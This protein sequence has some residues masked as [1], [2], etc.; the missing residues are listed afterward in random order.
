MKPK[1]SIIP[2]GPNARKILDLDKK[3]ISS[4]LTR[5]YPLVIEKAK[6]VSI[7]D[8]DGNVFLD[9]SSLLGVGNLGHSNEQIVRTITEQIKKSSHIGLSDFYSE[10]PAVFADRLTRF[11][12]GKLNRVFFSNSG[13]ESVETAIKLARYYTGRK[14]FLAFHKGYHGSTTCGAISLTDTSGNDI[15]G[16]LLPVIHVPY[17][18]CYRCEFNREYPNCNLECINYIKSKIFSKVS[19][20]N[21]AAVFIEPILGSEIVVPPKEFHVRL[22]NLCREN[23][24]LYIADEVFTGN[25]RTGK[26]LASEYFDIV[27]DI[28]CMS[29]GIGGGLP[30]GITIANEKIMSWGEGSHLSTFGGNSLVCAVGLTVLDIFSQDNI[31]KK[32]REDGEYILRYFENL[33]KHCNLIGNIRGKGLMIGVEIVKDKVYK[34]PAVKE[35]ENIILQ[36]F[37]KGLILHSGESTIKILPPLII[38]KEDIDNGLEILCNLMQYSERNKF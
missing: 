4:S 30:L 2:P 38:S 11:L 16:E 23:G 21:I 28:V 15:F 35:K 25:F 18:Y 14:Y 20:K 22:K 26:F 36:A 31:G 19:P 5:H 24:V 8:V 17:P 37:K 34:E 13:S 3:T 7:E 1:I 32:V 12:P 9:F 27:P 6:G 29:K 10:L 33:K